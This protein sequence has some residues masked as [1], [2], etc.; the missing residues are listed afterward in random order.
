M[1]VAAEPVLEFATCSCAPFDEPW[2]TLV[3]LT[4]FVLPRLNKAPT[5]LPAN[6]AVDATV[7]PLRTAPTATPLR[8]FARIVAPPFSACNSEYVEDRPTV[9]V[10]QEIRASQ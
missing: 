9:R 10:R 7:R 6:A 8:N 3:P 2:S 5:P 1:P 4:A